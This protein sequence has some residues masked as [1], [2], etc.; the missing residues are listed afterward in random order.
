MEGAGS[1]RTISPRLWWIL[2]L[3]SATVAAAALLVVDALPH[4]QLE[5]LVVSASGP[6]VLAPAFASARPA[7]LQLQLTADIAVPVP[8]GRGVGGFWPCRP[9]PPVRSS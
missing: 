6:S 7:R 2:S 5:R 4:E 3:A 9:A 8:P 1:Q